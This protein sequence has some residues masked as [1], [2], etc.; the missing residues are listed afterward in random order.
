MVAIK[1]SGEELRHLH[2]F[3]FLWGDNYINVKKEL[4]WLQIRE[5]AT[6]ARLLATSK[7]GCHL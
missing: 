3:F 7:Y 4:T 1:Y 2:K 6:D 5:M